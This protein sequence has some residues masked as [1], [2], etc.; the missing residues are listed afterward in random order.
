M[1]RKSIDIA[2][3]R[4]FALL[5][6]LCWVA[7]TMKIRLKKWLHNHRGIRFCGAQLSEPEFPVSGLCFLPDGSA[8]GSGALF[9]NQQQHYQHNAIEPTATEI[10]CRA[11]TPLSGRLGR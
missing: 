1:H 5:H 7:Y 3:Q 8:Y 2:Y 9:Q 11:V 6:S 4:M 10:T